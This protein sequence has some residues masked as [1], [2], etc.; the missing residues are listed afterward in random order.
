R[1]GMIDSQFTRMRR[2]IPSAYSPQSNHCVS[3]D[4][5]PFSAKPLSPPPAPCP[6]SSDC[7]PPREAILLTSRM[8]LCQSMP[9]AAACTGWR[10]D[11]AFAADDDG[12]LVDGAPASAACIPAE[13]GAPLGGATLRP[14]G[15]DQIL[16]EPS[17]GRFV[18]VSPVG[19]GVLAL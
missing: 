17:P 7:L 10:K 18:G 12:A 8:A 11:I 1:S 15:G 14:L 16:D 19:F 13:A 4:G 3:N 5:A 2:T 9:L 6:R